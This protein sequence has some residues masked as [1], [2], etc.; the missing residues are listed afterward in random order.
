MVAQHRFSKS[1]DNDEQLFMTISVKVSPVPCF[2]VCVTLFQMKQKLTLSV[3]EFVLAL[4]VF[5][6]LLI[7]LQLV[8]TYIYICLLTGGS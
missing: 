6:V 3:Y 8:L 7:R 2:A 5:H 4:T 1:S